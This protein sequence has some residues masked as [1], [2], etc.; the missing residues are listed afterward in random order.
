MPRHITIIDTTQ[1][2]RLWETEGNKKMFV[3]YS[4]CKLMLVVWE[5]D[6]IQ[7]CHTV[8]NK[9]TLKTKKC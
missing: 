6:A 9:I 4:C 1:E 3:F 7:R 8:E 5:S 2:K